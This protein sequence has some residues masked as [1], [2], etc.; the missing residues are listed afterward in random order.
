MFSLSACNRVCRYDT[1]TGESLDRC[2]M[3]FKKV[4][5]FSGVHEYF[6]ASESFGCKDPLGISIQPDSTQHMN[7]ILPLS[8]LKACKDIHPRLQALASSPG[9]FFRSNRYAANGLREGVPLGSPRF[10]QLPIST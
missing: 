1:L 6:S 3:E 2:R 4:S 10:N 9:L 5:S 8:G 7:F